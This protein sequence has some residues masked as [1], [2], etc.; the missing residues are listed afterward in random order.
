MFKPFTILKP[1]SRQ[2]SLYLTIAI[3]CLCLATATV[4]PLSSPLSE[5]FNQ[6]DL[7]HANDNYLEEIE[8]TDRQNLLKLTE[9]ASTLAVLESSQVG[10]S[11]LVDASIKIGKAIKPLSNVTEKA[12]DLT[13]ASISATIALR[14][15]LN[16]AELVAPLLFFI[17]M[18]IT[19][20]YFLLR[21]Y[22]K[23]NSL[24]IVSVYK[25]THITALVF[26]CSHI[27]LPYSIHSVA[28]IEK[29]LYTDIKKQKN[30]DL[31]NLHGMLTHNDSKHNIKD[32]IESD[33]HRI[34]HLIIKLPNKVEV[35]ASYY[36]K[37]MI[38]TILRSI[39]FPLAIFYV[40]II[41]MRSHL[42]SINFKL[43][44]RR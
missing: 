35:L 37:H 30:T 18:L 28:L 16:F 6:N 34:E 21:A 26:L 10:I 15:I 17:S 25:F 12:F 3:L 27:I 14:W 31:H 24:F 41:V 38:L 40:F 33:I 36:S 11:I 29:S 7:V 23:S 32:K 4:S 9:I 39:I 5:F 1:R 44:E 8:K 13:L 19:C 42:H 2:Q 43:R 22:N 20:L